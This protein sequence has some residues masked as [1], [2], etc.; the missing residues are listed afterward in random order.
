ML[1]IR[2]ARPLLWDQPSSGIRGE[3]SCGVKRKERKSTRGGVGIGI[4]SEREGRVVREGE[5]EKRARGLFPARPTSS[6]TPLIGTWL[7]VGATDS[8]E[9]GRE[10]ELLCL[11]GGGGGGDGGGGDGEEDEAGGSRERKG[12][13][14]QPPRC[15]GRQRSCREDGGQRG[16]RTRARGRAFCTLRYTYW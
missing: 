14:S 5:K 4:G 16:R 13:R 8:A 1:L 7:P 11:H 9:G 2:K 3:S 12:E 15:D 10:P 6:K